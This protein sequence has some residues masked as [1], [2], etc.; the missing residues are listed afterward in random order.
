M[1]I[2]EKCKK[3]T[4]SHI[5]VGDGG[6][7]AFVHGQYEEWCECCIIK[8][9]LASFRLHAKQIPILEKK[10]LIAKKRCK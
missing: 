2:C 6:A 8:T 7:M 1:K 4:A 5:W 10:L 3:H 9:Q